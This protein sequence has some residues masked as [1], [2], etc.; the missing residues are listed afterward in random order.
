[1]GFSVAGSWQD[2]GDSG[3]TKT[4]KAA[5]YDAGGWWDIGVGYATGPYKVSVAYMQSE[6]NDAGTGTEDD[7]ISYLSVGASYA[8]A[9]GLDF[10]ATY[11]YVDLD[12]VGT[13]SD[14]EVNMFMVGTQISF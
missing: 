10:Y 14:N 2:L 13:T 5:G 1:M 9:P 11:Q 12:Q 8:A 6:A 4:N 3:V 7:E